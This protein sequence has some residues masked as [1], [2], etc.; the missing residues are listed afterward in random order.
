MSKLSVV[1]ICAGA[2]GQSLGLHLAGF[3]HRLAV[4]IDPTAAATLRTNLGRL[5]PG[6]DVESLVAVGDVADPRVWNPSEFQAGI[7]LLAGGVPCPPFSVAGKQLG[8]NDERD[9]FAWAVELAGRMQ[10]R[11]VM[12]ENVRGLSS[13]RFGGYRQA[14]I[15][16]FEELGYVAD[17]ELLEAK[18]Y[19]VP[20][21]RPRFVLVALRPEDAA[22][23][24]WPEKKPTSETVGTTLLD[25]MSKNWKHADT[26]AYE[27]ATGIAP[28]IV[29]GSKKHGGADLGPTRAKRA[30]AALGVDGMG[31][32]NEPPNTTDPNH[33]PRLTLEMVERLQGWHG[34]EY[35]WTFT[36]RKTSHYRQVGNAFP[37]P[38]AR[39]VGEAI[40]RAFDPATSS[41]ERS[42]ERKMHDEVYRALRDADD[43]MTTAR[44]ERTLGS[45]LTAD[46]IEARISR[47][48]HD[49]EVHEAPRGGSTAW[50]LG[51][52]KAFRGQEDH[53]RHLAFADHGRRRQIS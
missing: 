5:Q 28:T 36:G 8:A 22:R 39:A 49:F 16:R 37:P 35:E 4:E 23:F 50:K 20:Q 45:R 41:A 53:D 7:D 13:T 14:V 43:W 51:D 2:G 19:G 46:E 30:W 47:L 1:E 6:D 9:L 42:P 17:W 31:I 21:L 25:L 29:G 18:D 3:E 11:A 40:A 15:D 10:P 33:M 24:E 48:K 32:A 27:R 26:W 44:I 12:L 38:V 34:P 52:F